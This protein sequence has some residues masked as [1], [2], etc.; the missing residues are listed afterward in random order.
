MT[1][2]M[3]LVERLMALPW[4]YSLQVEDG[5]WVVTIAELPDFFAA[6]TTP[7]EAASNAREALRSHLAGY[8]ACGKPIPRAART[9]FPTAASEVAVAS[10]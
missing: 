8:L 2:E 6:G 9:H 10:V 7:G 3:P 5:D 4:S 1:Y